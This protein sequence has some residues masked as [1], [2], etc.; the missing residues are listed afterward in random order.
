MRQG[1]KNKI[2]SKNKYRCKELIEICQSETD[3]IRQSEFVNELILITTENDKLKRLNWFNECLFFKIN[4]LIDKTRMAIL[5]QLK[6]AL[7]TLN[8]LSVSGYIKALLLIMDK[9]T[10]QRQIDVIMNDGVKELDSLLL[11]WSTQTTSNDKLLKILPQLG[12]RLHS[13]LEQFQLLGLFFCYKAKKNI[14][15]F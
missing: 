5:E 3:L 1:R 7:K 13:F 14:F 8:G 11:Q 10:A 9:R 12:N 15:Y 4:E 6:L 2:Y